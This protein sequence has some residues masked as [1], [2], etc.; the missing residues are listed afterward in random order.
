MTGATLPEAIVGFVLVFFA[1]GY[2]VTR[3]VFPEWR[4]RGPEASRRLVEIVTLSFVLSVVLTVLVGYALLAA[5]PGGFQAYWS[6]PVLEVTLAAIAAVVAVA[7]WARGAFG[8][9][10]VG[11]PEAEASAEEGAWDLSRELD[12]LDM[13]ARRLRHQLRTGAPDPGER[14]R[15]AARLEEIRAESAELARQREGEYAR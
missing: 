10:P 7:A 13:E 14:D 4:L 1:P 8:R 5:A 2:A 6:D 3:A 15:L 9:V 12:R 11:M